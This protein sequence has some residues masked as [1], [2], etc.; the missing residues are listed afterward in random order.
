MSHNNLIFYYLM[1]NFPP[2]ILINN[3]FVVSDFSL[4]FSGKQ[5][6]INLN[7]CASEPC[8]NG[9]KCTDSKYGFIC[10][11]SAPY[12]GLRCEKKTNMCQHTICQHSVSCTDLGT[13][14]KCSCLPGYGGKYCD[15]SK[16]FDILVG[17]VRTTIVE[18]FL[19]CWLI[20]QN[21]EENCRNIEETYVR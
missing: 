6:E 4:G 12:Y 1:L 16:Y 5:C 18:K 11:C 15:T 3:V 19:S 10:K 2:S 7:F 20:R 14:V 9:G 21:L 8:L 17:N 13:D